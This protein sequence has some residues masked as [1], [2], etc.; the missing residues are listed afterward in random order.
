MIHLNITA[1]AKLRGM[2]HPH[3]QLVHAGISDKVARDYLKGKKDRL[4]V[5]HIEILCELFNCSP[6]EL[7]VWQPDNKAKDTPQHPLQVIRQQPLPDTIQALQHVPVAE[8]KKLMEILQ[9]QKLP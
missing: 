6:N 1:L 8:V 2:R 9:Q 7:F 5:Q 4:V 3:R